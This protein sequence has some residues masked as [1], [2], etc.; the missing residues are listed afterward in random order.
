MGKR[1]TWKKVWVM[2]INCREKFLDEEGREHCDKCQPRLFEV[3][4][5]GQKNRR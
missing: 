1:R 2:C 4:E 5:N 3:K